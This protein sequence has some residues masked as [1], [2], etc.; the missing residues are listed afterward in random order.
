MQVKT[1]LSKA[2]CG[3]M[4]WKQLLSFRH[5]VTHNVTIQLTSD[6]TIPWLHPS[7]G[8]DLAMIPVSWKPP[9][10]EIQRNPWSKNDA[11][12]SQDF[13]WMSCFFPFITAGYFPPYTVSNVSSTDLAQGSIATHGIW[14]TVRFCQLKDFPC[15]GGANRITNPQGIKNQGILFH[16]GRWHGMLCEHAISNPLLLTWKQKLCLISQTEVCTGQPMLSDMPSQCGGYSF[17][18]QKKTTEYLSGEWGWIWSDVSILVAFL[19][20]QPGQ[21]VYNTITWYDYDM[22]VYDIS[23]L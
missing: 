9:E 5:Q 22:C 21:P 14:P 20:G 1:Q 2:D 19:I 4:L 23:R 12:I 11:N 6:T 8:D 10:Q 3:Q 18:K 13:S 17:Q 16:Y 15:E 7:L